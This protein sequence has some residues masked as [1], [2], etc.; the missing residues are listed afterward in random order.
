MKRLAFG[1]GMSVAVLMLL[2]GP[3]L[4]K[5]PGHPVLGQLLVAGP[6]LTGPIQIEGVLGFGPSAEQVGSP[7]TGSNDFSAFVLGTGLIPS[8]QGYFGLKPEGT[9]GP[10]YVVTV[11]MQEA[12]AVPIHQ[13]LYPYAA[14]GPVLFN[15]PD[16]T[17]IYGNRLA[18]AWWYP[19]GEVVRILSAYGLP[20]TPPAVPVPVAK[21]VHRP[22]LDSGDSRG[23]IIAGAIG[24]L[25]LLVVGG[26][27][28]GRDRPARATLP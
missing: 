14:G 17:G 10:R 7:D 28:L 13:D 18:S 1:L 12:G 8:D 19:N 15:L 21:S 5:G 3:A 26:A 24:A 2:A 11:T 9:L 22:V 20:A 4:A 27:V 25:M 23:W 6:G 16:Q